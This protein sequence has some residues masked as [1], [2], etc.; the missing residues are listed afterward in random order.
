MSKKLKNSSI[1]ENADIPIKLD[2][3]LNLILAF[4][5]NLAELG[6]LSDKNDILEPDMWFRYKSKKDQKQIIKRLLK[7]IERHKK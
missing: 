4:C 7:I 2:Y 3:E 5:E 6:C 1:A